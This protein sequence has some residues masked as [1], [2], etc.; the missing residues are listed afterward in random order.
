MKY[1]ITTLLGNEREERVVDCFAITINYPNFYVYV[2]ENSVLLMSS[3]AIV[4]VTKDTVSIKTRYPSIIK[5][6]EVKDL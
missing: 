2:A 3:N 4:E 5:I 6:E 1:S